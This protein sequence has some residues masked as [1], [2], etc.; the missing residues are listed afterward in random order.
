MLNYADARDLTVGPIGY[1]V[2]KRRNASIKDAWYQANPALGY[3]IDEATIEEAIATSSVEA[4]RTETL[5]QWVSALKSP[6]PY[7][8]C[9]DLGFVEK[10]IHGRW[11]IRTTAVNILMAIRDYR[12]LNIGIERGA[13][14]NAVL[15]YLSDL[16]RKSNIYAHIIDLT[17]GNRK[18]ADRIICG[19]FKLTSWYMHSLKREFSPFPIMLY[20]N[21]TGVIITLWIFKQ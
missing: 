20:L 7:R 6:W 2:V 17:H 16:M 12:P 10:I 4:S 15:P 1:V 18:K 14:K 8:A 21:F 19:E 5:C 13:L 11:D 3:L 9:E